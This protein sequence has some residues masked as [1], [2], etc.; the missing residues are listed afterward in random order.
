MTP[1]LASCGEIFDEKYEIISILGSGGMGSVFKARQ[2]GLD[3]IVAI[4]ILDPSLI[5]DSDAVARFEREGK[6]IS[7]LQ[8][9]HIAAFYS[10]GTFKDTPYIAMEYLHGRALNHV[11]DE[12]PDAMGWQRALNIARQVCQAMQYAH[13]AGIIHRDLK[14]NNIVLEETPTP[15]YVKVVDF[16][17]AKFVEVS[18]SGKQKLTQ[19]GALIGSVDY[20]SPEQSVGLNADERSDIYSLACTLFQM[21][22]GRLPFEAD[23]PVGMIHKHAHEQAPL[24]SDLSSKQFPSGL[25]LVI[26]KAME[27][28][29]ENRYQ[30]MALF[31][32]DLA[33]VAEERG[34]DL[35]IKLPR[36][37][38]AGKR[39]MQVTILLASAFLVFAIMLCGISFWYFNTA[40]GRSLQVRLDLQKNNS[41]ERKLYWLEKSEA[42]DKNSAEQIRLE[43]IRLAAE[44]DNS[45]YAIPKLF[46][47][48]ATEYE[49]QG[50]HESAAK[51]GLL[52]LQKIQEIGPPNSTAK[53]ERIDSFTNEVE[54]AA[55]YAMKNPKR[56][57]KKEAVDLIEFARSIQAL[58]GSHQV[59][60]NKL[61]AKAAEESHLPPS[62]YLA[63]TLSFEMDLL[64]STRRP[65]AVAALVE[66]AVRAERAFFGPS[67]PRIPRAYARAARELALDDAYKTLA[68]DYLNKAIMSFE[69]CTRDDND[70]L[71]GALDL[72][73]DAAD[74][75][76]LRDLEEK[77]ARYAVEISCSR[78]SECWVCGTSKL[79]LGRALY[80]AKKSREALAQLEQGFS[81]I[82]DL[83]IVRDEQLQARTDSLCRYLSVVRDAAQ[84]SNQSV[85]GLDILRR[86]QAYFKSV[87]K[88]GTTGALQ[89]TSLIKQLLAKPTKLSK[90]RAQMNELIGMQASNADLLKFFRSSWN[91]LRDVPCNAVY[92]DTVSHYCVALSRS[93]DGDS[94]AKLAL[95]TLT[96]L[97][98]TNTE[99][100]Y[101]SLMA[102]IAAQYCLQAYKPKEALALVEEYLPRFEQSDEFYVVQDRFLLWTDASIA[103]LQLKNF[104]RMKEYNSTAINWLKANKA[105]ATELELSTFLR[106]AKDTKQ[107]G[108][109][110]ESKRIA[111]AIAEVA[112][113]R[114]WQD[115]ESSKEALSLM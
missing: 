2:L 30:S 56:F 11:L 47:L 91:Q 60:L 102:Q 112:K 21:L 34:N 70:T 37:N 8:H 32:K 94:A 51:W 72:A 45:R 113:E 54:T 76:K 36:E 1:P 27:K 68:R 40:A 50:N 58:P 55:L 4:K 16:G 84:A 87:G 89:S 14:P 64:A 82:R 5:A 33:L 99:L 15:D 92:V 31:E 6:S 86:N 17:L 19:T 101:S 95:D 43:I 66:P 28:A 97:K 63:T 10:Y 22:T 57:T 52:S 7:L 9:N 106:I 93:G 35:Q 100:K 77:I 46:N 44:D 12:L 110:E 90:F 53:K 111:S 109:I 67:N 26:A 25:E 104:D 81:T 39:S 48:R 88:E 62:K 24:I 75:L 42:L 65:D 38:A 23:N 80:D 71:L 59:N 78:T 18:E 114:G 108:D 79:Q 98:S 73:T 105:I 83:E 74:R 107:I 103:L 69:H 85:T 49:N 13:A 3:R 96:Q 115:K 20:L 41:I 61:I 29:P